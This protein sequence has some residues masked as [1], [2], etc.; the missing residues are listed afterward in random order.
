[1]VTPEKGSCRQFTGKKWLIISR[2][3]LTPKLRV[4]ENSNLVLEIAPYV[5]SNIN[6]ETLKFDLFCL[7]M[8]EL[9]L[10][11]PLGFEPMIV[12]TPTSVCVGPVQI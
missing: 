12:C 3:R 1:M 7:N 4:Y 10:V 11:R 6:F 8:A 2:T 9:G 5:F